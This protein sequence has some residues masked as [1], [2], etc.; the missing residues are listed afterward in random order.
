MKRLAILGVVCF[1]FCAALYAAELSVWR[2]PAGL[3]SV[4]DGKIIKVNELTLDPSPTPPGP[5]PVPDP[6]VLTERA[7]ALKLLADK[8]ADPNREETAANL[9]GI[10]GLIKQQV[11]SGKITGQAAIAKAIDLGNG[12]VLGTNLAKAWKPVTDLFAQQWNAQVQD[13]SGDAALSAY[14][15]EA[16][17]GLKASA[18]SYEVPKLIEKDG[19]LVV[20]PD[21][22]D[23]L[24]GDKKAIDIK[25]LLEILMI[26]MQL[27]G[28]FLS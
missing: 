16:V 7:K 14:L 21:Y 1:F 27:I 15:G 24:T 17:S 22:K 10:W 13:N 23:E 4:Q 8:V 19:K 20:A 3:Y 28:P 5:G 6:T 26:I 25:R 11:D 2:L 18:P 12:M 9:A